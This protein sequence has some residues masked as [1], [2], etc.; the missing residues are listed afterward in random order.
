LAAG[1]ACW[2]DGAALVLLEYAAGAGYGAYAADAGR[3]GCIVG[4]LLFDEIAEPNVQSVQQQ[5]CPCWSTP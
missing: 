1:R 2:Y 4:P 3:R 5:N